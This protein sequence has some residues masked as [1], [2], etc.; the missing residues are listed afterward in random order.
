MTKV[1]GSANI[2]DILAYT[3]VKPQQATQQEINTNTLYKQCT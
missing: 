1:L 3:P 2:M